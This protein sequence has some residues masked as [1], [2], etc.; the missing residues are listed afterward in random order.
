[1]AKGKKARDRAEPWAITEVTVAGFK[2]INDEQ[3]IEVRPLTILAGVNSSGKLS[4][5]QPLLL[6]KQTLEAPYDAGPLQLNGPIARFTS[7]D[8]ILSRR[9]ARP[10]VLRRA[11][12]SAPDFIPKC[13]LNLHARDVVGDSARPSE[14]L[15]ACHP[16]VFCLRVLSRV[17]TFSPWIP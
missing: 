7:V 11:C 13:S 4:M 3:S 12:R 16:A 6:L 8:Q 14:Y 2:S 1:M 9:V 10:E 5:M 15:R 17:S